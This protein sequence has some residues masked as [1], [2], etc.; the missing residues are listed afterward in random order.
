[1][2]RTPRGALPL[3]FLRFAVV[4]ASFAIAL[5]FGG[6]GQIGG[7]PAFA[8]TCKKGKK[9]CGD[10]CISARKVCKDDPGDGTAE[11]TPALLPKDDKPLQSASNDAVSVAFA[12]PAGKAMV[13]L[14]QTLSRTGVLD[15]EDLQRET[16]RKALRGQRPPLPICVISHIQLVREC[17]PIVGGTVTLP[18]YL[19]VDEMADVCQLIGQL[20]PQFK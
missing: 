2:I 16:F 10:K 5:V 11:A 4:L 19:A 13:Q 14:A 12:S 1:M 9:P 3:A 6:P 15:V 7:T 8:K 17:E 18:C 20:M